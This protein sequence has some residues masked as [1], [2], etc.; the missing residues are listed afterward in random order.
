MVQQPDHGVDALEQGQA[1]VDLSS[2]R[3]VR[4][5]G[6][7]ARPWLHD[8]LTAPIAGLEAGRATRS[9]L[10]S[11]TGRIRAD[12]HV[13]AV[14]DDLLLL[15]APDQPEHVGLALTPYVLSAD[16]SLED[17]TEALALF[18]IPG[19]GAS[20]VGHAGTSPSVLG[21]GIDVLIEAGRSAWRFEETLVRAELTEADPSAVERWRILSGTPRM[22]PDFTQDSLPAEAGLEDVIDR[23][24]GCFLGQ[25]SVAKVRNLGH[26][27]WLVLACSFLGIAEVGDAILVEAVEVGH[28]TSVA[29]AEPRSA[30]IAR[31]RWEARDQILTLPDGRLLRTT[32]MG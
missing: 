24:K 18:A 25:E 26:P 20:R 14:G 30:A 1:F 27:P 21:R 32:G 28:L 22:G 9:L 2:F 15:Q 19:E 3:K 4:V 11:P 29:L 8:L 10:L 7:D 13:A 5:S 31:L 16:V 17:A 6:A 12:V 23:T